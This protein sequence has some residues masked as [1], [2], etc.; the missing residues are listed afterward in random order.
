VRRLTV[1]AVTAAILFAL[2]E[3]RLRENEQ[4]AGYFTGATHLVNTI[5]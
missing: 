5:A 1:M 3:R 2:R 4:R